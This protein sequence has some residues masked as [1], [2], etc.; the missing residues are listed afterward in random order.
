MSADIVNS[1][2]H[3]PNRN[4]LGLIWVNNSARLPIFLHEY[5]RSA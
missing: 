3:I 1:P 4:F 5:E 2:K